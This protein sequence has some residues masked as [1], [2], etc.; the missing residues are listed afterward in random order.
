M[1][2]RNFL[3]SPATNNFDQHPAIRFVELSRRYFATLLYFIV[4]DNIDTSE[5]QLSS[6][7]RIF[8]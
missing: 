4:R 3:R 2:L 8:N 6:V 5:N 1:R 7:Q